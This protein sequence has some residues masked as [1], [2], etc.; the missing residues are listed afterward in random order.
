MK[1]TI[2][3]FIFS[4]IL[5]A[6]QKSTSTY[7]DAQ[8]HFQRGDYFEAAVVLESLA[9]KGDAQAQ[10]AYGYMNYYG[11][12]VAQDE[13]EALF[14]FGRAAQKGNVNAEAAIEMILAE[15]SAAPIN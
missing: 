6:C 8:Q 14:W 3:I 2:I 11:L 7:F 13:D 15:G 12:G 1:K 4:I 9:K 10:Y 5:A